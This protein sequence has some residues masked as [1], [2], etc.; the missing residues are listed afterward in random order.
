MIETSLP[1]P[2]QM[3]PPPVAER[4]MRHKLV[5]S[6]DRDTFRS[7][8]A[9]RP[10]RAVW[11]FIHV[12]AGILAALGVGEWIWSPAAWWHALLI[13]LPVFYLGT[14]FN[15]FGVQVHEASHNLLFKSRRMNEVFCNLFGAYWILNDVESYRKVHQLHHTDLHQD[16][17]PDRNLYDLP[18]DGDRV[19]VVRK[20]CEDFFWIT[21]MGRMASYCNRSRTGGHRNH[22]L[23]KL[24]TQAALLAASVSVFGPVSGASFYFVFWLIPLFSI[25]PLIVR[26]RIV[27]EHFIEHPVAASG[28][29]FVS[30]STCAS[31]IE[32]YLFGCDM[33]YHFEHHL[34]P[35]VPH[36]QLKR[37][38][39]ALVEREFFEEL[40]F[41]EDYLN[42]GYVAFWLRLLAGVRQGAGHA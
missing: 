14:R 36:P 4:A 18:R 10:V 39:A 25:F 26:L 3:Q 1:T 42:R 29:P 40:P 12:W 17:D 9:H 20:L 15:A 22:T 8:F 41:A 16:T 27:A 32:G 35:G 19:L 5:N 11:T 38:H 24:T 21:A 31:F 34:L 7:F 37:L 28:K 2:F 23:G 6:F 33:Q 13:P 30:R